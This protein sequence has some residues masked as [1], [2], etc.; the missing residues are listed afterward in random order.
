[1]VKL[2][3]AMA[4]AVKVDDAARARVSRNSEMRDF[5]VP[6]YFLSA[7]SNLDALDQRLNPPPACTIASLAASGQCTEGES[8]GELV[9]NCPT[10]GIWGGWLRRHAIE[11]T[12]STGN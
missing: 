8:R 9:V 11:F 2:L 6:P 12:R 5:M 10:A 7:S 4:W 1:M 3:Q